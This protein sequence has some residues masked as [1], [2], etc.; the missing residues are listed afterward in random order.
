MSKLEEHPTVIKIRKKLSPLVSVDTSQ[1]LNADWLKQK[2]LSFGADDVGFVEVD[3]AE[4]DPDRESIK[5]Y[6]PWTKTLISFVCRMNKEPV[7]SPARSVANLEFHHTGDVVDEVAQKI[8]ALLEEK[9]IRAINPAM[10]FPMEMNEFPNKIWVI[11]HK[12]SAIAAGLGQMGIHRNVIH[13][14]FGNFI[15]LGTILVDATISKQTHPIEYNPCLSCKLCVAACPVGAIGSD[16]DFNFSACYNHNYKEFLGGFTNWVETVAESKKGINYRNKVTD[17]ESVSIW[18]SLSYGANYKAAYCMAVCPA[19]EDVISPFLADRSEF[20]KQV[21]K[22]LQQKLEPVYVVKGSD[23][24]QHVIKRYPHKTV[25]RLNNGLRPTT[26]E[27]FLTGLNLIFQKKQSDNIN[28]RYHFT[29]TGD[30][31]RLATIVIK[32]K[33]LEVLNGLIGKADLKI[34]AD[35]KVWLKF[36]RKEANLVW[37]LMRRKIRIHG[38]PMLLIKFGKCFLA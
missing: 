8:V 22:P 4:L 6:A 12:L 38:N 16:G 36:I 20:V 27:N 17:S 15:L 7:R 26:T 35:S 14:K 29:F 13:P 21:V 33:Q 28:A 9:N 23:A 1:E 11:S 3:R 18:Q 34:T 32:D 24:E 30:E 2:C 5:K 31:E 19:G 25:R 10:G 37:A